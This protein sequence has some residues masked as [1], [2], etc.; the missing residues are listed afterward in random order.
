MSKIDLHMH[1]RES[2]GSL[3][4]TELVMAAKQEGLE[5]IALTDHDT[6]SGIHEALCAGRAYGLEVIP[7]CELTIQSNSGLLHILG[8]WVNHESPELSQKLSEMSRQEQARIK[9]TINKLNS[10]GI[11]IDFEDVQ[12]TTQ[13]Q[14]SQIH[15]ASV[16]KNK[17]AVNSIKEAFDLFLGHTGKAFIPREKMSAEEGLSM[18]RSNGA[19]P[20]LAHP[21]KYCSEINILRKELVRLKSLGLQGIEAYYGLHSRSEEIA[22]EQLA[23]E[24]G[25]VLSGGS[26]FHGRAKPQINMGLGNMTVKNFYKLKQIRYR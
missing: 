4:P 15:I 13:G 2:D 9:I 7:G 6:V 12:E 3:S 24:L 19:I 1:S 14:I 25:L 20:I 26:D 17:G 11:N 16:L 8:L 5:V 18:L 22:C 21:F 10:L 23:E